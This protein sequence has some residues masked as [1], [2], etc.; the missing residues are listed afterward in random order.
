MALVFAL[1]LLG[2]FGYNSGIVQSACSRFYSI[3]VYKLDKMLFIVENLVKSLFCMR[4]THDV[5]NSNSKRYNCL[6]SKL[7][8]GD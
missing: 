2:H 8:S 5:S 3:V 6:S 4:S 7:T 1:F